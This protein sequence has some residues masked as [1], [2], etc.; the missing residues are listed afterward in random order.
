MQ[1]SSNRFQRTNSCTDLRELRRKQQLSRQSQGSSSQTL[2]RHNSTPVCPL[3]KA[4][5]TSSLLSSSTSNA[6]KRP[7]TLLRN[8]STPN[9]PTSSLSSSSSSLSSK[10]LSSLSTATNPLKP[11][12]TKLSALKSLPSS[13]NPLNSFKRK[14]DSASSPINAPPAKKIRKPNVFASSS[15]EG[16]QTSLNP[17]QLLKKIDSSAPIDAEDKEEEGDEQDNGLQCISIPSWVSF[18]PSDDERSEDE[19]DDRI[20]DSRVEFRVPISKMSDNEDDD[21]D[22]MD[23]MKILAEN[24]ERLRTD[25]PLL[26]LLSERRSP[27]DFLAT[28]PVVSGGG[29]F[30]YDRESLVEG[31][32]VGMK[33]VSGATKL[34]E[35]EKVDDDQIEVRKPE[36]VPLMNVGSI[37]EDTLLSWVYPPHNLAPSH[38]GLM[39]K[40]IDKVDTDLSKLKVYE[41]LEIQYYQELESEWRE[42]FK[43]AFTSFAQHQVNYMYYMNSKFAVVFCYDKEA[44]GT[45]KAILS[46]STKGLRRT[47]ASKGIMF[48]EAKG[49][50]VETVKTDADD[51]SAIFPI[52]FSGMKQVRA[53]FTFLVAWQERAAPLRAARRPTIISPGPFLY[54]SSKRAKVV[55]KKDVQIHKNNSIQVGHSL[56]ITGIMLPTAIN[57][58]L[59]EL[60]DHMSGVQRDG[61]HIELHFACEEK[62]RGLNYKSVEG[63]GDAS[64]FADDDARSKRYSTVK[65]VTLSNRSITINSS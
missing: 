61:C 25:K 51:G 59:G 17:F 29:D 1:P 14:E 42:S 33:E 52:I 8:S 23:I 26:K 45:Q 21:D 53:L 54:A 6:I 10:P 9:L 60:W 56:Q 55:R 38:I 46:L 20:E 35:D 64:N 16:S 3:P 40:L 12:P 7:S 5:N 27:V 30:E 48:T 4:P 19:E 2:Q 43:S 32:G 50:A 18:E 44:L 13:L 34:V 58:I 28:E 15:K 11:E 24:S 39:T 22:G 31:R 36:Q 63:G 41:K 49:T 37:L 57:K 62:T 47:L 65:S